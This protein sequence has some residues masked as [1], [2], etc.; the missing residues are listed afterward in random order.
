MKY[1][2][3]TVVALLI[4]L[5]LIKYYRFAFEYYISIQ[6]NHPRVFFVVIAVLILK[7]LILFFVAEV[8]KLF[9]MIASAFLDVEISRY[10]YSY[11][12]HRKRDKESGQPLLS[13]ARIVCVVKVTKTY[14]LNLFWWNNSF[15]HECSNAIPTASGLTIAHSFRHIERFV[16]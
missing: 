16:I 7:C 4:A 14:S 3:T 11:K 1:N 6:S 8:L 12:R 2:R 13:I 15:F 9:R 10:Q 5:I